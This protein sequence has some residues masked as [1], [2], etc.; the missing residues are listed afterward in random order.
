MT[1]TDIAAKKNKRSI[2]CFN[3]FFSKSHFSTNLSTALTKLNMELDLCK[4]LNTFK[5]DYLKIV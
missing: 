3:F 1:F 2:D 5:E 4:Q